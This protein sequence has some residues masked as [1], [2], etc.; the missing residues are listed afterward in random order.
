MLLDAQAKVKNKRDDEY[1]R[2]GKKILH[3]E[4]EDALMEKYK[5]W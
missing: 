2:E 1:K 5:D 3:D 4:I